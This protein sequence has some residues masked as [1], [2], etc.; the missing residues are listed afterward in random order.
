MEILEYAYTYIVSDQVYKKY[1]HTYYKYTENQ[2]RSK[3]SYPE[4]QIT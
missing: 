2:T 3:Y 4:L 1:L